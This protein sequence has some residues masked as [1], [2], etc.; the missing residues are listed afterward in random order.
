MKSIRLLLASVFGLGL[1]LVL[2]WA[3]GSQMRVARADPNIRYVAPTGTDDGDGCTASP[4][5]TVQYAVNAASAG[6]II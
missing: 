5:R 6:D 3:L 4:C 2:L 1:T